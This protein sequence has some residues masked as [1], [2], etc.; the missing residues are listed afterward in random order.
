MNQPDEERN[1]P[2]LTRNGF[3]VSQ[4]LN[5]PVQ[6]TTPSA[7]RLEKLHFFLIN[8]VLHHIWVLLQLRKGISLANGKHRFE[9]NKDKDYTTTL[10]KILIN[11]VTTPTLPQLRYALLVQKR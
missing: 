11:S 1:K 3:A 8:D 4:A 6:D 10:L 2:V 9:A 7:E 5:F